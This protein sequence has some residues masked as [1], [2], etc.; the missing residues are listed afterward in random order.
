MVINK[1]IKLNIIYVHHVVIRC[2]KQ[3]GSEI[4]GYK[5]TLISNAL[6]KTNGLMYCDCGSNKI[7][8]NKNNKCV[9]MNLEYLNKIRI[10]FR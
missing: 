3:S 9:C 8:L 7:P 10:L 4:L 6:P 1:I 2:Y 5:K